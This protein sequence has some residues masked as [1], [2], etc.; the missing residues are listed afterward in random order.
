MEIEEDTQKTNDWE[1]TLFWESTRED[2]KFGFHLHSHGP[3][4]GLVD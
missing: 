4:C 3:I 1:R 2:N